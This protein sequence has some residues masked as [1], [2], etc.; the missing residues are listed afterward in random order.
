MHL[1]KT[2]GKGLP[3][4]Y[5]L[6]GYPIYG[7]K[8]PDGS[9]VTNL[10]PLNG[11]KDAKGQYH[12]HA[13]KTYPYLN[14]GFYGEVTERGGQVDPQPRAEPVRPDLPAVARC[15][16]HRLPSDKARQLSFDLRCARSE[17]FGQLYVER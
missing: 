9:K 16:N 11:H 7:Y 10:D 2:V 14:G 4:A 8:E 6:D 17:G 12:Y 3:I 13:T 5:A 15:Q 1:E